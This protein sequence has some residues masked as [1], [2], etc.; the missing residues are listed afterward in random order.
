MASQ[1]YLGSTLFI[2]S[3]ESNIIIGFEVMSFEVMS[4]ESWMHLITTALLEV[5]DRSS[6]TK[7]QAAH[8]FRR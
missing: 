7:A 3:N 5:R 1:N 4:N 8:L 2:L 6:W